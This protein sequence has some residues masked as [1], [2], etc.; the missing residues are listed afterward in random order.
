[1]K[2]FGEELEQSR[3]TTSEFSFLLT[4]L[5]RGTNVLGTKWQSVTGRLKSVS[6]GQSGVWGVSPKNEV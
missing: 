1:M 4:L 6:V 2:Q 3:K 5:H